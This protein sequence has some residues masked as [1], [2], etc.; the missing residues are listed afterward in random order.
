MSA[1]S[2]VTYF[3][4]SAAVGLK[5]SPFVHFIA[6]TTIAIALFSAGM[7]R[8]AARVLDNLLASLGGEVE[9]TVY[10]SPE[11]DADEVHGVRALVLAL[12]GGEVTLV[13]PDAALSRLRTELGDLGEALAELPENP[14]PVSLE[15]RVPPERRNPDALLALAKALRAAPGVAGVDYGEAAVQRLSAIARALRFGSLVAFAVVLGATV[16]IV[17]ATLQLAIYSRRGEIEIQKLVGATDR[18]VKAPFLLEGLLQG[19][20][21]AAVA[22]FGLWAFGRVLGP[23][24]GALFAFLLGPGVAAPWV[25]PRLALELLCAGCGLGLGGSFVAVGRFLRV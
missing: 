5:H 14:L 21:G 8:G 13:S 16:V 20:L 7:A 15:L 3:C 23:T 10:L 6:V 24:L 22:L 4:R 11:L 17:A 18:F 12:S 25:E 2:K 1:L 9:V 19:V